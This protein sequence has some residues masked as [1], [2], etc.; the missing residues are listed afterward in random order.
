LFLSKNFPHKIFFTP[1]TTPFIMKLTNN[2]NKNW[3]LFNKFL[4]RNSIIFINHSFFLHYIYLIF[5]QKMNSGNKLFRPWVTCRCVDCS[6]NID[7][8]R[9]ICVLKMALNNNQN[10]NNNNNNES[11]ILLRRNSVEDSSDNRSEA[12]SSTTERTIIYS[13]WMVFFRTLRHNCLNEHIF[14][15]NKYN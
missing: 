9:L 6:L 10:N 4:Y 7:S 14:Y 8:K 3:Y 1:I 5:F 13:Q 11:R 12:N 15:E 2:F